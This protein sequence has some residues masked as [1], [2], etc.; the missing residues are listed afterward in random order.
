MLELCSCDENL[1]MGIIV[2][3]NETM[4]KITNERIH[5]YSEHL[6]ATLLDEVKI[7]IFKTQ[8]KIRY[9]NLLYKTELKTVFSGLDIPELTTDNCKLSDVV[10]NIEIDI[11]NYYVRTKNETNKG[12]RTIRKFIADSLFIYYFRLV[13]SNCIF[14]VGVYQ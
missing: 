4:P 12:Y 9:T 11:G 10:Q 7:P 5:N 3:K 8:T 1:R 13:S 14:T 6:K 2:A